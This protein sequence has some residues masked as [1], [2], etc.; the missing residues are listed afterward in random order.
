MSRLLSFAGLVLAFGLNLNTLSAQQDV[1]IA[2]VDDTGS[3]ST[4]SAAYSTSDY[5]YSSDFETDVATSTAT[6]TDEP[7][8][9]GSTQGSVS[10]LA[11]LGLS[12]SASA[13]CISTIQLSTGAAPGYGYVYGTSTGEATWEV[14]SDTLP[15][16]TPVVILVEAEVTWSVGGTID[17]ENV[18]ATVRVAGAGIEV[19]GGHVKITSAD[20]KVTETDDSREG[21]TAG[22]MFFYETRI[23]DQI[24]GWGN[25]YN[26]MYS[27]ETGQTGSSIGTWRLALLPS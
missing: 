22:V 20:G 7:G 14:A 17:D 11:S 4:N 16:G 25:V 15:V 24:N 19:S 2:L 6:V 27:N 26:T 18:G 21:G 9:P 1:Y 8:G 13:A 5:D 10:N 3:A 23:G 12:G